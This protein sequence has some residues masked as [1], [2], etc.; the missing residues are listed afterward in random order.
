MRAGV[1]FV[2]VD[3]DLADDAQQAADQKC[4]EIVHVSS[5]P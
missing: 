1:S 4:F 5:F 2:S 3:E